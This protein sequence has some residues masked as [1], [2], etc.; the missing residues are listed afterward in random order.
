MPTPL[1]AEAIATAIAT[2]EKGDATAPDHG[3]YPGRGAREQKVRGGHGGRGALQPRTVR[4]R[5]VRSRIV[6]LA[7]LLALGLSLAGHATAEAASKRGDQDKRAGKDTNGSGQLDRQYKLTKRF[8]DTPADL[9]AEPRPAKYRPVLASQTPKHTPEKLV[10]YPINM[11]TAVVYVPKD[12]KRGAKEKHGLYI[13]VP[14]GQNG[15]L[16]QGWGGVMDD[17]KL[18]FASPHKAG[19]NVLVVQRMSLVLDV[20]ASLRQDFDL[21]PERIYIGGLSGGGAMSGDIAM[22][23]ARH[24]KGVNCQVRALFVERTKFKANQYWPASWSHLSTAD[25]DAVRALGLRWAFVTGEKD[26][27]YEPILKSTAGWWQAGFDMRVF[28]V[29]G[30]GHSDAS[31]E[32]LGTV[33]DWLDG[34]EG[35]GYE[36]R[37]KAAKIAEPKP[38]A[39]L[40]DDKA[41]DAQK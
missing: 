19:N 36:P 40:G 35:P 28:D 41:K 24:F 9:F 5:V 29:P 27:N 26:F 34:K 23:F 14:A 7:A 30:M 13:H 1:R 20:L 37:W 6:V 17:K 38:R 32:V 18:I 11:F 12:Y 8:V 3:R 21:D 4:S 22:H 31:P 25:L 15:Y 16:R 10:S 33:I 2:H 39:L